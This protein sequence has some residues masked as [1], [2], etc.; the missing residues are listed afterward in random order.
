[1]ILDTNALS[2]WAEGLPAVEAP[3]QAARRLV[4]PSIVLGEYLFGIRQSRYLSRYESWLR[5][6]LPLVEIAGVTEETAAI[7]ADIRLE[8]KRAGNPIPSNDVWIAAV[9][10]Q[11]SLPVL[12]ND[13][14]FDAV[15]G[16]GRIDFR[17]GA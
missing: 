5:H 2:A 9:A 15:T 13:V 10:R 16:L 7:Y 6:N 3:M 8:L 14:H 1:M 17:I 4:V 12:S 11:Q